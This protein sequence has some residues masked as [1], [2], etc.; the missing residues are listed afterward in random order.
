MM[1]KII[2][3]SAL[4]IATMTSGA[5][6]Q[7]VGVA[8]PPQIE[9]QGQGQVN[10]APDMAVISLGVLHRSPRAQGAM[11]AVNDSMD[12]ILERL[13]GQGVDPADVQTSQLTVAIDRSQQM[14]RMNAGEEVVSPPEYVAT[15][16]LNVRVRDLDA[17][18]GLLDLALEDG[19]NQMSGLRFDVQDPE[20]LEARARI[21]AVKDA[22]E[23]AGQI[24]DAAG[25]EL[26]QVRRITAFNNGGR[27]QMMMEMSRSGGGVPVAS[28]EVSI[29]AQVSVIFDIVQ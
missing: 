18:G 11:K 6:A 5:T 17:L 25:V 29:D 19:V 2:M 7:Q 20:P 14:Q 3:A 23:Q 21:L 24:A 15:S 22:V 13:T 28:G 4:F 8:A 12:A 16:M 27:P 1:L 10:V 26:G 9:V